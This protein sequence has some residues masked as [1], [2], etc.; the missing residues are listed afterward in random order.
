MP[1]PRCGT[2]FRGFRR[3][4]FFILKKTLDF[5]EVTGG[6]RLC[7]QP[8]GPSGRRVEPTNE[9]ELNQS[10]ASLLL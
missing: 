3:S 1:P 10:P 8:L 7:S 6:L 2:S 4:V 9:K 5:S